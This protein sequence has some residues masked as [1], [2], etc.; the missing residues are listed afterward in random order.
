MAVFLNGKTFEAPLPHMAMTPV[1]PMIAADMTGHPPLH[2]GAERCLRDGLYD[3]M[4]MIRHQIEGQECD[5]MF[6]F[7]G[8]ERVKAGGVVAR[9]MKDRRAAIPA[10][11]VMVGR[12]GDLTARNPR[13]GVHSVGKISGSGNSN[14]ACPLF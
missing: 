7:G 8:G 11:Q 9:V 6:G 5:G 4:K 13:H 10:I 14:V 12:S 2:E 1:M 3:E